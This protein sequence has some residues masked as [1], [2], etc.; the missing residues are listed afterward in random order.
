[1]LTETAYLVMATAETVSDEFAII[2]YEC[3]ESTRNI[4]IHSGWILSKVFVGMNQ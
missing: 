4:I 2:R 3:E 1:M